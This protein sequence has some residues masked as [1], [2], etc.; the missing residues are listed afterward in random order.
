[1]IRGDAAS[2]AGPVRYGTIRMHSRR[3]GL[4][5][6]RRSTERGRGYARHAVGS[7]AGELEYPAAPGRL[8][9]DQA[10]RSVAGRARGA[11]TTGAG[12]RRLSPDHRNPTTP[13]DRRGAP[14]RCRAAAVELGRPLRRVSQLPRAP[15]I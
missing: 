12:P 8:V 15:A 1:M 4:T 3:F 7:T 9:S 14:G 6:A 13:L 11:R 10:G 5:G 2:T